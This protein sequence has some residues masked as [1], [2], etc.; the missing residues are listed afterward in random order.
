MI[1]LI[2]KIAG[3]VGLVVVE[4]YLSAAEYAFARGEPI[5]GAGAY[6]TLVYL[7]MAAMLLLLVLLIREEGE[8]E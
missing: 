3:L 6:A 2:A 5:A 4:V 7:Q 8:D 1:N